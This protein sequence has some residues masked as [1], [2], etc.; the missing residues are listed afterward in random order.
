MTYKRHKFSV[1]KIDLSD[2]NVFTF[3]SEEGVCSVFEGIYTEIVYIHND[4][5]NLKVYHRS[6]LNDNWYIL[7]VHG[8]EVPCDDLYGLYHAISSYKEHKQI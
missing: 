5:P 2:I 7:C 4:H 8:V 3:I 1:N 6:A